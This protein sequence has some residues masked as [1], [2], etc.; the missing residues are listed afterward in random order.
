MKNAEYKL[1]E[2]K[3]LI[4][5]NSTNLAV[6]F[7]DCGR[8]CKRSP[9]RGGGPCIFCAEDDLAL[10]VGADLAEKYVEAVRM[11]RALEAEMENKVYDT[12]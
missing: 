9:G 3:D 1:A 10:V 12:P 8:K 5:R 2:A 6:T 11:L 7:G 4:W